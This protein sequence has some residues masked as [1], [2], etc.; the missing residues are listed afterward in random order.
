MPLHAKSKVPTRAE[1]RTVVAH[2]RPPLPLPDNTL[3]AVTTRKSNATHLS[4]SIVS[5]PPS[6]GVSLLPHSLSHIFIAR[7]ARRKHSNPPTI[8]SI[9]PVRLSIGAVATAGQRT[10]GIHCTVD[11]II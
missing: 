6:Q 8:E 10:R 4:K 5:L 11:D 3:A 7:L 1:K 2:D 9:R